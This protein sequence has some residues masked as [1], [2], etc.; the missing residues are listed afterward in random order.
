MKRM[1]MHES[2]SLIS[3]EEKDMSQIYNAMLEQEASKLLEDFYKVAAELVDK[4]WDKIDM[5][6]H[7]LIQKETLDL[8]QIKK[9]LRLPDTK[10]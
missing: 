6:A 8:K 2:V 3:A 5:L 4:N 10:N 7:E 1:A 9:F